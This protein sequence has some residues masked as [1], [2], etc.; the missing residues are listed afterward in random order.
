MTASL[1]VEEELR[2]GACGQLADW[3]DAVV[4]VADMG[5]WRVEQG[6]PWDGRG[7]KRALYWVGLRLKGSHSRLDAATCR[8]W[9]VP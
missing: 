5:G 3:A 7:E 9:L 8:D 4:Q 2:V 6:V 1:R